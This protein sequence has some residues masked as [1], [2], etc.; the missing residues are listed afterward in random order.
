V[1][2]SSAGERRKSRRFQLSLSAVFSWRD[3]QG[4][5]QSAEGRSSN[6]S[7][8]G[9]YIRTETAPAAGSAVEMN[10]F[11]P[12]PAYDLRAAEI[13]ATGQVTRVDRGRGSEFLGFAA[14]NRMV[15]IRE[16]F[17]QGFERQDEEKI[18]TRPG[19]VQLNI[20]AEHDLGLRNS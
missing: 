9:I 15:L 18:E 16:S 17:E 12:Q 19:F 4:Q 10:V 20:S 7:S 5:L 3:E 6:I 14:I 2:K 8:R 13:R 11:L 1:T